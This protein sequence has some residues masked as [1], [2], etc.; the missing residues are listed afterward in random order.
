[1]GAE[2]RGLVFPAALL[3]RLI[4]VVEL[5]ARG[6]ERLAQPLMLSLSALRTVLDDDPAGLELVER[7]DR[8]A[9]S[10]GY[11]GDRPAARHRRPRRDRGG[12]RLLFF[13]L[14]PALDG[15]LEGRQ[16]RI[17]VRPP[18]DDPERRAAL[19]A[20]AQQ[21]G[22]RLAV[23][24]LVTVLHADLRRELTGDVDEGSGGA[25]M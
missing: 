5:L 13:F 2:D 10:G 1:M 15:I 12:A 14:Q 8:Q 20:E 9:G 18:G 25:R 6:R 24:D 22:Q 4:D 17:R 11:A 23:R 3:H 16:R 7:A 21:R 19:D